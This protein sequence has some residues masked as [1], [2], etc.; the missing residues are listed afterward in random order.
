MK[1][2]FKINFVQY[3][4]VGLV[5]CLHDMLLPGFIRGKDLL[6]DQS[7]TDESIRLLLQRSRGLGSVE[8]FNAQG[9]FVATEK[10]LLHSFI[11]C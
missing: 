10:Q 1:P 3:L 5:S 2:Y 7:R 6:Q 4:S 8:E 11:S 9:G